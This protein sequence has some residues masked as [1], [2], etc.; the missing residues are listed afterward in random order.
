VGQ[1]KLTHYRQEASLA[2]PMFALQAA[3]ES[4]A[5]LSVSP[6]VGDIPKTGTASNFLREFVTFALTLPVH[7]VNPRNCTIAP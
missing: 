1:R 5:R 6:L 3:E 7:K 4:R 2:A